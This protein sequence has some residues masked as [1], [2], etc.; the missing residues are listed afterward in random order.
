[1]HEMEDRK[2]EIKHLLNTALQ[3][4][5]FYSSQKGPFSPAQVRTAYYR[6]KQFGT[7]SEAISALPKIPN[8]LL[9]DLVQELRPLLSQ[10]MDSENK[11][12]G[13]GMNHIL[14][15]RVVNT[16]AGFA[17]DLICGTAILGENRVADLLCGWIAGGPFY[18][19]TKAVLTGVKINFPLTLAEDGIHVNSLPLSSN[20]LPAH[21]PFWS[22]HSTGYG[23]LMG[24]T[25]LSIDCEERPALY[26]PSDDRRQ[27]HPLRPTWGKGRVSNF[28]IAA[29][30]QALSLACN[31]HIS[32]SLVW[33]DYGELAAFK[34]NLGS[35]YT[36]YTLSY[37]GPETILSMEQ[38]QQACDIF[39]R[40]KTKAGKNIRQNLDVAIGRWVKS[41][42]TT[43]DIASRFIDLRIAL[44]ALFLGKSEG[45]K[46]FR[47]AV[48][49][50]WYI[51]NNFNERHQH[52]K[53]LRK[54]YDFASQVIHAGKVKITKENMDLLAAAQSL[55]RD[56]I[57]KRLYEEDEPDWSKIILGHKVG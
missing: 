37:F 15:G 27:D 31:H 57:L 7:Y 44:E 5:L 28:H 41:K 38:L 53:I 49:G 33:Q 19:K 40:R 1:M 32:Q 8:G 13:N 17:H 51:G 55:C 36:E 3:Q 25:F 2:G 43:S 54:A 34:M 42:Q 23:K 9:E 45:E 52:S 20:K 29:F 11:Y 14:S 26:K 18:Y 47:L 21:I 50:A 46:R 12:M 24:K 30:C 56:G 10:Y 22:I 4:T 39:L 35:A 16:I 6:Q 48:H